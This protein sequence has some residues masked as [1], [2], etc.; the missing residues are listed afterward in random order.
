MRL[1]R[2]KTQ[3]ATLAADIPWRVLAVL[4]IIRI[5]IV[6]IYITYSVLLNPACEPDTGRHRTGRERLFRKLI[7]A[8][9]PRP[10]CGPVLRYG[11]SESPWRARGMCAALV[12]YGYCVPYFVPSYE[13]E[14]KTV[15]AGIGAQAQKFLDAG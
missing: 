7:T 4:R 15:N 11:C 3:L 12:E 9:G 2:K 13:V 1:R 5:N 14:Y 10:A 6:L 8:H